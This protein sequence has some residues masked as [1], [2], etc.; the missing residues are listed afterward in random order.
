MYR[1][2]CVQCTNRADYD[3][4]PEKGERCT[5]CGKLI[6]RADIVECELPILGE[7]PIERHHNIVVT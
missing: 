5:R 2:I 4:N 3:H 6:G 1:T 7:Q